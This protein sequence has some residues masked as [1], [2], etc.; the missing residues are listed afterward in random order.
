[1]ASPMQ[2]YRRRVGGDFVLAL[3][4]GVVFF[5]E[6]RRPAV[7]CTTSCP[8]RTAKTC[9]RCCRH[10]EA[11]VAEF[12]S[13]DGRGGG[14][15]NVISH[16]HIEADED[17]CRLARAHYGKV[18]PFQAADDDEAELYLW[19]CYSGSGLR[20]PPSKAKFD[21]RE[22][23]EEMVMETLGNPAGIDSFVKYLYQKILMGRRY[24]LL[25]P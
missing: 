21:R 24:I 25:E 8:G 17:L 1:M 22:C 2:E 16:H 13:L 23:L 19:Y 14:F 20:R 6:G 10:K 4:E 15:G 9:P 11:L 7:A 5:Q 12:W 18:D 3:D